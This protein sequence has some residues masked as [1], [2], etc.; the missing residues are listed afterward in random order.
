[1]RVD[2]LQAMQ[3]AAEVRDAGV[4]GILLK[5][6]DVELAR[7]ACSVPHSGLIVE[8][9]A[10]KGLSTCLLGMASDPSV[11]VVTI[12]PFEKAINSVFTK[13]EGPYAD[14]WEENVNKFRGLRGRIE[15]IKDYS[16]NIGPAWN[17]LIDLLFIDGDHTEKG[18]TQDVQYFG[19]WLNANGLLVMHDYECGFTG[20]DKVWDRLIE[21]Q[22]VEQL[23]MKTTLVWGK[24]IW[25][26]NF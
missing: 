5:D 7:L 9:G 21:E 12:D 13:R 20:I 26:K 22:K 16:Y 15:L 4:Q 11:R 24:K 18:V 23:G 3:V 19:P 10:F 1:M 8:I 14:K 2:L 25:T 17:K 6:Q